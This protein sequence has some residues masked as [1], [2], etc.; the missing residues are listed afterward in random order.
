MILKIH[1]LVNINITATLRLNIEVINLNYIKF[2][3]IPLE[4]QIEYACRRL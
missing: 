3:K 4:D 1:N 2:G